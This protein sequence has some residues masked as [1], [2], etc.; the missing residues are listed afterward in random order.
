MEIKS[1]AI[2]AIGELNILFHWMEKHYLYWY[3]KKIVFFVFSI[4]HIYFSKLVTE[5]LHNL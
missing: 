4:A 3:L 1:A 5:S 2:K